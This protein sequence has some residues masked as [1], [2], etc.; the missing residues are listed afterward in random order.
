MK[1]NTKPAMPPSREPFSMYSAPEEDCGKSLLI[2]GEAPGEEEIIARKPFVGASGKLLTNLLQQAGLRREHFAITNVFSRRPPNNDLK[3]WTLTKTDLKK[4][5]IPLEGRLPPISGRYLHPDHEPDLKRLAVELS[6]LRPHFI[7]C[8]GGTALWSLIGDARITHHR[9]TFF[10][11]ALGVTVLGQPAQLFRPELRALAT[12]HPAGVMRQWDWR[13]LVW[14][15]LVK[16]RKHLDGTLPPS[17]TRKL[18][19]NPTE[20]EIAYVYS[21]FRGTPDELLGVDI[22]TSP[23]AGQITTF[24]IGTAAEAICIPLWNP[25]SLPAVCHSY[26]DAPSEASARRWIERFC[27]LP[28]PKVMQNGLYDMQWLLDAGIRVANVLHDTA[29][30]H[31]AMQ[32]ELPKDL[33]TLGSLYLNEPA[34]K[35]MRTRAKDEVKADE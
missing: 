4:A 3:A 29:I 19:I 18:W 6:C 16:V 24:A 10:S 20:E 34:W 13:P 28:N 17:L 27:S 9:G 8:L 31:H 35:M 22:E 33:G 1:M 7:I 5:G 32:P 21:L 15:D 12:F 2:L 26:G 11:P 14:A 30:L 23:R 25:Q